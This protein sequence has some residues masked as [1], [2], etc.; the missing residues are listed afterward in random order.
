MRVYAGGTQGHVMPCMHGCGGLCR[1][2]ADMLRLADAVEAAKRTLSEAES[3]SIRLPSWGSGGGVLHADVT[4]TQ[5]EEATAALRAR[6][7]PPLE[8]LGREACLEWAQRCLAQKPPP[9]MLSKVISA[10]KQ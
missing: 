7:G 9:D 2:P 10:C 3:A 8:R 5:F 6:L 4:R 1:E